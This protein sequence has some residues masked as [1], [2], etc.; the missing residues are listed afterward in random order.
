MGKANSAKRRMYDNDYDV[1]AEQEK[2]ASR[3]IFLNEGLLGTGSFSEV[4]KVFHSATQQIFA[5]KR[6]KQEMR[7]EQCV[8]IA[9]SE[10]QIMQKLNAICRR[11]R[12]A[13]DAEDDECED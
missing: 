6:S 12:S 1:G 4:F 7:T 11:R 5:L 3:N 9:L 10:V 13:A 2:D 8:D